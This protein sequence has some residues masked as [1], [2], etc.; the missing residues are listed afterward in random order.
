MTRI[1]NRSVDVGLHEQLS[2]I[3]KL[4]Q[5]DECRYSIKLLCELFGVHRSTNK[6]WRKR[7]KRITPETAKLQ[8]QVKEVHRQSNGSAGARTV[9]IMTT[10]NGTPCLVIVLV[11]L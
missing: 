1:R 9:V 5:S 8:S 4:S 6:Y 2:V 3:E 7:D 10:K 11:T